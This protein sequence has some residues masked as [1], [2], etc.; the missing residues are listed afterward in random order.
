MITKVRLWI[1]H[2]RHRY[3]RWKEWCKYSKWNKVSKFLVLIGLKKSTWFNTFMIN[4]FET[5]EFY[6]ED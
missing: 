4:P 5:R 6:N 2:I 1:A 3:Y